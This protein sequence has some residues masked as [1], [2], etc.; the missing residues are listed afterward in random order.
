MLIRRDGS[1][2]QQIGIYGVTAPLGH[3]AAR[4]LV[5]TVE[6]KPACTCPVPASLAP[7]IIRCAEVGD[8]VAIAVIPSTPEGLAKQIVAVLRR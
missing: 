1:N 4:W 5:N 8:G 2:H 3:L 7:S 6:P